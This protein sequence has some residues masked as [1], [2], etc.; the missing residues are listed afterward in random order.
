MFLITTAL[1]LSSPDTVAGSVTEYLSRVNTPAFPA[2]WAI[3]PLQPV[4]LLW[5]SLINILAQQD[6]QP[7]DMWNL[8]ICYGGSVQCV[9]PL[10]PYSS[11][12]GF[13]AIQSLHL[14]ARGVIG[15]VVEGQ[16]GLILS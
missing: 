16:Y 9:I 15:R 5:I 3:I 7:S 13:K 1:L 4:H 11:A 6:I 10:V 12:T 14:L 2:L 8:C